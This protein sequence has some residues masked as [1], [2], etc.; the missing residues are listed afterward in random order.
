M[1]SHWSLNPKKNE[2]K[3][4]WY[5]TNKKR[6]IKWHTNCFKDSSSERLVGIV[7]KWLWDSIRTAK[8]GKT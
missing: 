4:K 8:L 5:L 2:K 1:I 3:V 6:N 7:L